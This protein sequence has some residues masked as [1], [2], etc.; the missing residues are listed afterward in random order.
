[1]KLNQ[2]CKIL[3]THLDAKPRISFCILNCLL[4]A[5]FLVLHAGEI[6]VDG[7]TQISSYDASTTLTVNSGTA[8]LL[9]RSQ[10]G[11][12]HYR[13]KAERPYGAS[14][15]YVAFSEIRLY[16]GATDVTSARSGYTIAYSSEW[17]DSG[18]HFFWGKKFGDS[19]SS[20]YLHGF[21]KVL[22]GDLT[23]DVAAADGKPSASAETRDKV[24]IRIDFANPQLVTSYDWARSDYWFSSSDTKL[25]DPA[26]WRFQGSDDGETWTDLDVH[27]GFLMPAPANNR[28]AWAGPFACSFT[29]G[30]CE[31]GV[32]NMAEGTEVAL[33][34]DALRV[35]AISGGTL[36]LSSGA[37]LSLDDGAKVLR[38]TIPSGTIVKTGT[39][40]A[41]IEGDT[42]FG[43]AL[44]VAGGTL[45]FSGSGGNTDKFY[46]F[47]FTQTSGKE[48]LKFGRILFYDANGAR[49]GAGSYTE[50]QDVAAKELSAGQIGY[51]STYTFEGSNTP[52]HLLKGDTNWPALGLDKIDGSAANLT[53]ANGLSFQ[54]VVRL[55]DGTAPV[56][57]YL[58]QAANW[59][60]DKWFA[61]VKWTVE[62]S[63][64][65]VTWRTVDAVTA[66]TPTGNADWTLW[67]GGIPW[68]FSNRNAPAG[69]AFLPAATVSVANGA[70][71]DLCGSQ[72]T[73]IGNLAIDVTAGAGTVD[74]VTPVQGGCLYL[75]NL[76]SWTIDEPLP[77][78][79]ES[80]VYPQTFEGWSVF[81]DSTR[82][83]RRVIYRN[84]GLYLQKHGF[85]LSF[86]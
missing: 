2:M 10:R 30:V 83:A 34:T 26:D 41:E 44:A 47:T 21:S 39:G 71:L 32:I 42:S 58:F 70:W 86:R 20:D 11:Y 9:P 55:L 36:T 85:I 43:G 50:V 57:S 18:S 64:D 14:A 52:R 76:G 31:V 48:K 82:K 69:T 61:P 62:S 80:V 68:G 75:Y 1:M 35:G 54:F 12:R 25:P 40:T 24:W 56:K 17:D 73:Q 53:G 72:T 15:N 3:W 23:T 19:S 38:T 60:G 7:D 63:P 78:T 13:F 59:G 33:S 29:N 28:A 45:R 5:P 49:T 84:D 4:L 66:A 65:G 27:T 22:D 37:A 51:S 74:I 8:T 46:R 67:N 79:M 6:V 77:I 81:V 16:N